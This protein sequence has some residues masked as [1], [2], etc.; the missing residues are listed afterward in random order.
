M[1]DILDVSPIAVTTDATPITLTT[2]GFG[3][4]RA[5]HGEFIVIAHASD[6][7]K[8]S[9][10]F[11]FLVFRSGDDLTIIAQLVGLL[12]TKTLGAAL[13][14]AYLDDAN[15]SVGVKVKGTNSQTINWYADLLWGRA[16]SPAA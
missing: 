3:D 8:A 2:Y 11:S 4:S 1:A 9:W 13:W 16:L 7:N 10:Q 6:G 14:D 5:A 15:G 12:T